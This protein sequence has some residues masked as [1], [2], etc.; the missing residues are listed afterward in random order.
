MQPTGRLHLGHYLGV[1][2]NYVKLQEEYEC[3]FMVANLHSL[4][5]FY[6]NYRKAHSFIAPLVSDWLAA[7][8]DP[9]KSVIF[10]QSDI[11][12]HA[13]LSLILSMYTP[14]S[15]LLRNPTYKEK[16]ENLD[17]DID[18][19]GFLG[20]PVLQAADILLYEAKLVPIGEDQLPHLELTREIVRRFNHYQQQEIFDLPKPLL[21]SF[22]KVLG[23]DGRKMSKSY[24]NTLDLAES[25]ES[26]EKKL[27]QM[28]TDTARV[29]RQDPGNPENCPVFTYYDHFGQK[30]KNEIAKACRTASIGCRDCKANLF[31]YMKEEL[32]PFREMR[33]K[34]EKD[35]SFI[36]NI[37]HKGAMKAKERAQKTMIKVKEALGLNSRYTFP[38]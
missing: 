18:S 8:I 5:V 12:E 1:L 35:P 10:V 15:W 32:R 20:Y 36:E 9:E 38:A 2:M 4:T 14:V 30:D 23:T 22:P 7:G 11:P 33:Q 16:Q 37:L 17:K 28:K 27:M 34:A 24:G 3:Y 29:R 19:H 21:S 31:S 25:E 13:E 6:P 26:F